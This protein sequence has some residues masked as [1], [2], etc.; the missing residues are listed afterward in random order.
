MSTVPWQLRDPEFRQAIRSVVASMGERCALAGSAGA[1]IHIA[2]AIGL[3]KL[4]PPARAIEVVALGAEQPPP[5][6]NG[7]PVAVVDPRG[8]AGSI[9]ADRCWIEIGGDRFP[10]ASPEHILGLQLGASGLAPDAKWSSFLLMRTLGDRLDLEQVRG[11]LKRSAEP[12]RQSL[13]AELAYLA[14]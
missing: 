11:L 3:D 8:F 14:A 7:V 4:G 10:V 13:L 2:A 6:A 9:E 5:L 12:D 1:Q